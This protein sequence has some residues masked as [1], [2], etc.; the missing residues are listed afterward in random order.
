MK[1][2]KKTNLSRRMSS[3][4]TIV[5]TIIGRTAMA[6]TRTSTWN[7][8]QE[9]SPKQVKIRRQRKENLSQPRV[10]FGMTKRSR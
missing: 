5:M 9:I 8:H 3:N 7:K 1:T 4:A 2:L 6:V 10:R